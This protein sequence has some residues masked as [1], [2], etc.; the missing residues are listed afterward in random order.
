MRSRIKRARRWGLFE[1]LESR[2]LL[3]LVLSPTNFTAI[4]QVPFDGVIATLLDTKFND[5]PGSFNNPPGSVSINW[6]DGTPP[7]SGTVVGPIFPGVFEI[8]ASHTYAT[9]GSFTTQ[10]A[11]ANQSGDDATG[12]GTATVATT[13]PELTIVANAIT[14]TAGNLINPVVANFLDP[15]STDTASD[16]QALITWGDGSSSIGTI[17]G[18]NG[19]FTVAGTHDYKSAGIYAT[20]VTVVGL[21]N[22]LSGVAMATAAIG[23][24]MIATT[25][26]TLSMTPGVALAPNTTVATFT[27][28][29]MPA[30]GDVTAV[31]NWG[32]GQTSTGVVSGP[33]GS[34]VYSVTGEHTYSAVGASNSYAIS[35]KIADPDGA[36]ATA[37]STALSAGLIN[38]TGTSFTG[39]AG[40]LL[41]N[42]TV[43]SL[44]DANPDATASNISAVINWGDGQ[45]SPGTIS[46]AGLA[47]NFSV[48]GSHTYATAGPFAVTVTITDPSGQTVTLTSAAT[49][50]ETAIV[51][52]GLTFSTTPGQAL[53]SVPVAYFTDPNS[54]ANSGN[55]TAVIEWGDGQTTTGTVSGPNA[56][57]VYT[58]SGTH[59]YSA[60]GGASSYSVTVKIGDPAGAM[61]QATS[62]ALV[63]GFI[64]A[65][66]TSFTGTASEL[67]TGVTVANLTDSNP[68]ATASKIQ[69][70]IN[71]GDGQTSPASISGSSGTFAIAGSHAYA[72]AGSYSVSVTITDPSG[73]SATL[74]STATVAAGAIVA[75]GRTL[76][77]F[78][79]VA[80]TGVPVAYFTDANASANS[81]TI[82]AVV[83][84][85]DGQTTTGNI[86]GPVGGVYTVS[87][88]H[89]YSASN[90]NTS[91]SISVT[92]ADPTGAI[93]SATSTALVVPEFLNA[94]GTSF[95]GAV[96]HLLSNVTVANFTDNNPDAT[97]NNIEAVI[98]WSDGASSIGTITGSAGTFSVTGSHG[99][100]T[101]GAFAVTVTIADPS[102]QMTRVTSNASIAQSTIFVT[103]TTFSTTLGVPFSGVPVAYF[104]DAN[105]TSIANSATI[106]TVINWGDGQTS[107]GTVSGPDASGVYTVTG[108]HTYSAPGASSQYS[109]TVTVADPTGAK[110]TVTS[111]AL[112]VAGF[113]NATGTSFTGIV[114]QT[115]T[116]VTVAKLVDIN[117]DPDVNS[118]TI[119]AVISWGDG[120]STPGMVNPTSSPG[121]YS[122]TGNHTYST[123]NS[124]GSFSVK[125]TIT[126]PSGQSTTS[127]STAIIAAPTLVTTGTT[128]STS[129]AVMGVTVA[130]FADNNPMAIA[131]PSLISAVINWGDGQSASG[132]VNTTSTPGSFTVSGTHPY[133]IPSSTGS[134]AVTVTITVPS[135]QTATANS[136]ALVVTGLISSTVTTV[137]PGV[138]FTG[139]LAP[140]GDNGKYASMGYTNTNRPTFSGTAVPFSTVQLYGKFWGADAV[141]PLGETITNSIG[142]WTLTVGPLAPGTYTITATVTPAGGYPV[143]V[144]LAGNG[145]VYIDMHPRTVKLRKRKVTDAPAVHRVT[146]KHK[147]GQH[148]RASVTAAK[149]HHA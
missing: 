144:N 58:V 10:I 24:S 21:N 125:V 3:T 7:G 124:T 97:A 8:D 33:N 63:A 107:T 47:G 38:A 135:G 32:D 133:T 75:T 99:Y 139:S 29:N 18:S 101:A 119:M 126:D 76:S 128:F 17:T 127:T 42:V 19:A 71:W 86:S 102:G 12:S 57:G 20:N 54:S 117:P 136:T 90:T 123:A 130:S 40:Q 6:G 110:A 118:T 106:T 98:N 61:A 35:V 85:G 134:Y 146:V 95:T 4:Q 89:T 45:S 60:V 59:T 13:A 77:T 96:G 67:L 15:I 79:G 109:I 81:G 34:G 50:A 5:S 132:T 112:A 43:A 115:L 116:N 28:S 52:T 113:L 27:D 92:I 55:I 23:T 11:V 93:G 70:V 83:H 138:S 44:S 48:I 137:L 30:S 84:W 131:N 25:G 87:G 26:V 114:G 143:A 73:Q 91:Y 9:S 149:K 56:A 51:A 80:L 120:Q 31:I 100:S 111:T 142:Q 65:T 1:R 82:T 94:T 145:L 69:A 88:T 68:N 46:A 147:V 122:I 22:G 148:D 72:T 78:P 41:S 62:T 39:T 37:T 74:T 121:V 104:T 140:N 129:Q 108:S 141:Q 2:Q 16:F 36:M 105:P 66:G 103:G 14:G 53:T 64:N 49:I